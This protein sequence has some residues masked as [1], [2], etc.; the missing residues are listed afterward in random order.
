MRHISLLV[1]AA[2][3]ASAAHVASAQ[4][5]ARVRVTEPTVARAYT[6]DREPEHRAALG[7]GTTVT[8]TLRDTLGLMITSITKGSPA[9]KAG[10]EEG[11]RLAA[12][13]GVS[14]RV[15]AADVE[16]G[17]MSGAFTRRLVRELA[18]AKAGD[19]VTLTVY[20]DGRTQTVKVKTA[21]SSVLFART[22][23]VRT[24]RADMDDR[25]AL[26]VG[27]GGT[28]SRRDSRGVLGVSVSDSSPAAKAGIEEGNRIAAINGVNLRVVQEDAG[29]R[30]MSSTKAQRLQR[31][32]GALK[33]G[34]N[35][36]LKV[37]ANGKFRDVTMKAARAGDLPRGASMFMY[38]GNMGGMP[39]LPAMPRMP[40]MPMEPRMPME[41]ATPMASMAPMPSV[42]G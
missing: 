27:L 6:I 9:E 17:E 3:S 25:A 30:W 14:L 36:T 23:H 18:K 16:D 22:D 4:G 29:D 2:A 13:N 38:D 24:S 21:D 37:Y 8:G 34:D 32:V 7:V 40:L 33:P 20:R 31:E 41:P 39:M 11:N 10:L 5:A 26:G 12:I 42:G 19:E 15:N 35:V 28:G 1:I